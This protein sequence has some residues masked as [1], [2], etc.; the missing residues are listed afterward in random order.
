MSGE[1][2]FLVSAVCLGIAVVLHLSRPSPRPGYQPKAGGP[3]PAPPRTGS[4]VLPNR[5]L[6]VPMPPVVEPGDIEGMRR[7]LADLRHLLGK[8]ETRIAKLEGRT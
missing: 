6:D 5:P 8:A 1:A 3:R 7:E 4:A 2:W